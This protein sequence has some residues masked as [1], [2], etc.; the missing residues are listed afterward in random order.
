MFGEGIVTRLRLSLLNFTGPSAEVDLEC[1]ACRGESVGNP[2]RP[3]R[4]CSSEGWIEWGGC[5]LI[6]AI[7]QSCGISPDEIYLSFA[8]GMGI[9]RTVMFPPRDHRHA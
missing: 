3:Y 8:F 1:F 6:N 4:T 7:P 5:G 2:D 9:R